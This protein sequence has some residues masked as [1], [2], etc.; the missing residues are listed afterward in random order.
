[1]ANVKLELHSLDPLTQIFSCAHPAM[2]VGLG[3]INKDEYNKF[4]KK[5]ILVFLKK[6]KS[7]DTE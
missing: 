1:M 4:K 7:V 2:I 5:F 3:D 6:P